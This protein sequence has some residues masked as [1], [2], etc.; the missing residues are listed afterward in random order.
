MVSEPSDAARLKVMYES[1][2]TLCINLCMYF[3]HLVLPGRFFFLPLQL[4][5]VLPVFTFFSL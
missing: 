2:W 5:E 4:D 3:S 1:F